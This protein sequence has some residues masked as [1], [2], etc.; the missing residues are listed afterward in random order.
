M[1]IPG[2]S[3]CN[4]CGL[5]GHYIRECEVVTEFT[6]LGKCKRSLDGK[7]VLPSGAMVPRSIVGTWLRDRVEE[8][9]R[10]NPGQMAVAMLFEIA[11]SQMTLPNE[12]VG[13]TYLGYPTRH[14]D[15][16]YSEEAARTYALNQQARLRP[17]VMI[18]SRPPCHS[19]RVGHGENARGASSSVAPQVQRAEEPPQGIQEPTNKQREYHEEPTHSYASTPDAIHGIISGPTWP[20]I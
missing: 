16:Y 8:Y 9:H 7:V 6:R 13:H 2:T 18:T 3:A 11:T 1:S 15:Q 4:F 5:P 20:P 14:A 12:A 10:Q 17:E 19:G